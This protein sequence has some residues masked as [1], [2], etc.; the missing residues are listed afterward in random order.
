MVWHDQKMERTTGK[1][2]KS[3]KRQKMTRADDR[4]DFATGEVKQEHVGKQMEWPGTIMQ[5]GKCEELPPLTIGQRRAPQSK[6]FFE[7]VRLRRPQ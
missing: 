5:A 6:Q 4:L 1:C 2:A 7:P 3:V